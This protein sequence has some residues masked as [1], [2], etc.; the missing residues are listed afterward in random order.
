MLEDLKGMFPWPKECPD[1][2]SNPGGWFHGHNQKVIKDWIE[3]SKPSVILELGAWLGMSARLMCSWSKSQI[4]TIDHWKGS[5]EH[6]IEGYP[7]LPVLYETFIKN[8]WQ[9]QDRI[10]PVRMDTV[11]GMELV[12]SLNIEPDMVYV[13]ASHETEFVIRDL[14]AVMR[15]FPKAHI[16]G[17]DFCWTSVEAG[18][19]EAI[20]GTG[21]LLRHTDICYEVLV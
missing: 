14:K 7:F 1:V 18:V 13:D 16:I 21:R 4:I 17:D 6:S 8:C 15:T 3:R 2:E 20:K 5:S 11:D 10:I 12:K 9:Y 19:R